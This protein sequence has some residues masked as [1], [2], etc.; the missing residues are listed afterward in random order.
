MHSNLKPTLWRTCRVLA[1]AGRLRVLEHLRQHGAASVA[2]IGNGC[3]LSRV[4]A[5]VSLRALQARGLLR[6]AR[7]SRWV[8][9]YPEADHLVQ[10]APELLAAVMA[11]FQRKMAPAALRKQATAFTH[12]RR[13]RTISPLPPAANGCRPARGAAPRR[14]TRARPETGRGRRAGAP[15]VASAWW[16]SA[17]VRPR[18]RQ[19]WQRPV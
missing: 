19:S 2:S 5:T 6:A 1:N 16:R 8:I 14:S 4:C 12:E 13:I 3:G 15:A 7:V 17:S 11:A 18:C 10:H 9:Y